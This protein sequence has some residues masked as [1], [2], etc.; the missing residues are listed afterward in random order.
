M[1]AKKNGRFEYLEFIFDP[2]RVV[3]S[4]LNTLLIKG[5]KVI[6][7]RTTFFANGTRITVH[8]LQRKRY[9]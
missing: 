8:V 6:R 4:D 5:W 3:P 1:M 2:T 9:R 7:S